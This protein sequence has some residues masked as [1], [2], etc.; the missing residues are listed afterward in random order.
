[1]IRTF[2][3]ILCDFNAAYVKIKKIIYLSYLRM[4]IFTA[5]YQYKVIV[6]DK[7]NRQSSKF[8][9]LKMLQDNVI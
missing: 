4:G 7:L 8:F 9:S 5:N 1:M 6:S 2:H 3:F